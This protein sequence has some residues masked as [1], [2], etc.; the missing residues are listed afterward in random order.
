MPTTA[1]RLKQSGMADSLA[2]LAAAVSASSGND[3][4][5]KPAPGLVIHN[6]QITCA[7]HPMSRLMLTRQQATRSIV[8]PAHHVVEVEVS[9]VAPAVVGSRLAAPPQQL[10]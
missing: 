2:A 6:T 7:R 3:P 10:Q 8:R 5:G 1:T 4:P 9:L